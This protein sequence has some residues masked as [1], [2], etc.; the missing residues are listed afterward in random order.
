MGGVLVLMLT[1]E[2]ACHRFLNYLFTSSHHHAVTPSRHHII[3]SSSPRHAKS[4]KSKVKMQP[5]L[6]Q[7]IL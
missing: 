3:T 6:L 5:E 4:E 2:D 1:I 7:I